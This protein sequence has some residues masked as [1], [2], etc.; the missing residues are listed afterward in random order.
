LIEE[1]FSLIPASF[2]IWSSTL[3]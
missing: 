1:T 2:P 3:S